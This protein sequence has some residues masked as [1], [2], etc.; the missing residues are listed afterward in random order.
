MRTK[1]ESSEAALQNYSRA[2]NLLFVADDKDSVAKERLHQ[3][4]EALSKAQ[5]DRIEKQAQMEMAAEAKPDSVPQVLDN[6]AL[7][8]YE[9]KLADLQRQLAE[10][11]QIYTS[12]NP[13]IQMLESQI[14]SLE[15]SFNR[16]RES[17]LNRL[18]NEYQASLRN[19]NML[20]TAYGA[21]THVVSGQDEKMIRYDTLKH[22]VETNRSTYDMLLQK[23]K[24]SSV[25]VALQATSIRVV[26]AALPPLKP[27]KPDTAVDLAGG[28]LAGP[29]LGLTSVSLR[30][31]SDRK[32]RKPGVM[33]NYLASLELGVIPSFGPRAINSREMN[34]R[35]WLDPNSPVNESFRSV[36]TSI[37]FAAN[38]N[39][40]IHLVVITSPEAGEGK[41][42]VASNLGAAFAATGRRVLMVDADLRR[43]RLHKVFDVPNT[44]GLLEFAEEYHVKGPSAKVNSFA[45]ETSVPGLFIMAS[46]NC[47]VGSSNLF[48]QCGSASSSPLCGRV[49]H[50]HRRRAAAALRPGSTRH[51]APGRR[52][53]AGRSRGQHSGRRSRECR[54][55]HPPGWRQPDRHRSQ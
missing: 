33:Q 17:V 7:K 3:L 41:T 18:R 25:N 54:E 24:E 35:A 15:S 20:S 52:R 49:R 1:L 10:S 11:K 27:Y 26:D 32:V 39:A 42:T 40:G 36:M 44:P 4:Q 8:D 50:C 31:R 34:E 28:L 47:T 12:S 9:V 48:Q 37:L 23:V 13:K 30:H 45:T 46:G 51:G 43:P 16:T 14:T 19:E 6:A 21:Q 22:E 5:S 38:G 29:L 2:N 53:C 55:V